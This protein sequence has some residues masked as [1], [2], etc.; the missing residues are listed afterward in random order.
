[1]GLTDP[2]DARRFTS[3]AKLNADGTVA[4]IVE[5]ADAMLPHRDPSD[6]GNCYVEV[7]DLRKSDVDVFALAIDPAVVKSALADP[8]RARFTLENS[9]RQAFAAAVVDAI[10]A[11]TFG[12]PILNG[13]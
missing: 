13:G 12:G 5:I 2:H 3:F 11:K 8:I 6:D 9:F 7:T 4:A 10:D 1:M